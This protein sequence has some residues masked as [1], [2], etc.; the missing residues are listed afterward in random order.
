MQNLGL[1]YA[2]Y[3]ALKQLYPDPRAAAG[4]GAAP[5]DLLQ[6]P[7]L[8]GGGDRGRGALP[9]GAHRPR[10]GG[11]PERVTDFKA[12]LMG[13]A[14]GA[15]GRVLLALAQAGR[16]RAAA[17]RWCPGSAPGPRCSSW[18]STTSVHLT[19]RARL[20]RMGL[21]LGD[22]LV[23]A[24]AR[25]S[26]PARGARLRAVAAASAGRLAASWRSPSGRN[27][28]ALG[29]GSAPV[30]VCRWGRSATCW[31]PAK[32]PKYA[33]LYRAG[34]VAG[35]CA[36]GASCRSVGESDVANVAEAE[37]RSSTRWACT[38]GRQP[39]WSSWPTATSARCTLECEGQPVNGKSIMGVLML[40][41]AQG[42]VLTVALRGRGRAECSGRSAS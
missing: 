38:P 16:G 2:L 3:P 9:R 6:H 35:G 5:P 18:S 22:R 8:R 15:R 28:A 1:A 26:L 13:P 7:P 19:L 23:E 11:P 29:R 32:V 21:R 4:G 24:V 30:V 36:R 27:R 41:A 10:R 12:A 40:A 20:F 37:F 25:A 17:R 34:G 42:M 33:V 14:G 39:S 31:W